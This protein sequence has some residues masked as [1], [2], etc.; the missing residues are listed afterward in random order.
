MAVKGSSRAGP[1]SFPGTGGSDWHYDIINCDSHCKVR[2]IHL[3]SSQPVRTENVIMRPCRV[4]REGR[5]RTISY[6]L[7]SLSTVANLPTYWALLH[8]LIAVVVEN[9]SNITS[10]KPK[11]ME[12]SPYLRQSL[13]QICYA[14]HAMQEDPQPTRAHIEVVVIHLETA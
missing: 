12:P 3:A 13:H 1:T 5:S 9:I 11:T 10:L 2:R 4:A 6:R 14:N 8:C 7:F